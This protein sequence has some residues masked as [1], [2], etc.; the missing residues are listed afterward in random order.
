MKVRTQNR[1]A[2]GLSL[3]LILTLAAGSYYLSI[4]A[5]DATGPAGPRKLTHE[6]DY[7]VDKLA[8]TKVDEH[9]EPSFLLS[10]E[11]MVHFP[12]DGSSEFVQPRMVSLN[13]LR[14]QM[15]LRADTARTDTKGDETELRGKVVL[16]RKGSGAEPQ[17]TVRSEHMMLFTKTER[18]RTEGAVEILRGTASLTGVGME[19]D[20]AARHLRIDS[21]VR[22]SWQPAPTSR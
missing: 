2:A 12:D 9:G 5:A 16:I 13:P 8:L 3:L 14:P 11:R 18:A 21:R 4:I 17:L 1:L 20:N 6:P 7:F 10:A 19:F 15:S 22:G